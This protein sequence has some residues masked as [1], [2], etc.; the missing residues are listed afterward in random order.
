VTALDAPRGARET[1]RVR[2]S[3]LRRALA[4]G[5]L[6][7]LGG[8]SKTSAPAEPPPDAGPRLVIEGHVA[9]ADRAPAEGVIVEGF[10]EANDVACRTTSGTAGAFTLTCT[11]VDWVRVVAI[12][13]V[14]GAGRVELI[15]DFKRYEPRPAPYTGVELFAN[16]PKPSAQ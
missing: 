7:A 2:P 13:Q 8:C 11:G 3:T 9:W 5:A 1:E 14:P 4:V 6:V 12:P 16:R 15:P 10:R